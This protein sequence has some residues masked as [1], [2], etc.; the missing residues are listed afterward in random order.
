MSTISIKLYEF[1]RK[2]MSLSEEKAKEFVQA[3]DDV[4]K[5]DIKGEN[6]SELATKS[7]VKD[8][9]HMLELKLEQTKG[10]LTKAIFWAGLIQFLAIVGSLFGLINLM[11]HK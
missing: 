10:E 5:E 4:V 9:I 3:I 8:E 11:L 1:A 6:L 2:E 7:F